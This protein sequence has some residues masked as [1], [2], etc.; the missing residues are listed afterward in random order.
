MNCIWLG[1]LKDLTCDKQFS[2]ENCELD[3][4]LRNLCLIKKDDFTLQDKYESDLFDQLFKRIQ[5]ETFSESLFYLKNQL[6]LKNIFGNVYYLGI[7][8]VLLQLLDDYDYVH[9][10]DETEIKKGQ[11]ILT[12]EGKWGKKHFISPIDITIIEKINFSKFRL[13]KWYAIILVNE[14]DR[15]NIQ[16]TEEKWNEKKAETLLLLKDRK[17]CEPQI[18]QSMFDG[19][20]KIK[21]IHQYLGNKKY[22][23][24]L[25]KVFE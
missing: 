20:T 17:L 24:L 22:L 15:D 9:Q 16:L 3:K 10:P 12:L 21:F 18:G 11:V 13:H 4:V 23:E 5:G 14:I 1:L 25:S 6:V 8:P 2:C 19:G 7:N